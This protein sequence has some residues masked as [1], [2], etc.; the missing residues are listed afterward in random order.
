MEEPIAPGPI[1][2]AN[3]SAHS[4]RSSTL[5]V[6]FTPPSAQNQPAD[7]PFGCFRLRKVQR[8]RVVRRYRQ[9]NVPL[10]TRGGP[11]AEKPG[12]PPAIG[13]RRNERRKPGGWRMT[14]GGS[15]AI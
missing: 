15:G 9:G 4:A 1:G 3:S 10:T 12:V 11:D 2:P 13:E 8:F 7:K 6:P 5:S 14:D